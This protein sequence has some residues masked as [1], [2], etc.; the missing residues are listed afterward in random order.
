MHTAESLTD[1]STTTPANELIF[2]LF[3]SAVVAGVAWFVARFVPEPFLFLAGALGFAVLGWLLGAM[4]LASW[5]KV[6]IGLVGFG[7]FSGTWA[8]LNHPEW[9][10]FTL[11]TAVSV[12]IFWPSFAIG[13]R[14]R[15]TGKA[16]GSLQSSK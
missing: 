11:V 10:R 12:A 2:T 3:F 15:Y 5:W 9:W 7:C 8:N 16:A 6:F 4:E 13:V 14:I 1:S